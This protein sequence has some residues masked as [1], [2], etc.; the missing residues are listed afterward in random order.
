M[1]I[2]ELASNIILR[3]FLRP[4]E[5]ILSLKSLFEG[6]PEGVKGS[7]FVWRAKMRKYYHLETSLEAVRPLFKFEA[8]RGRSSDLKPPRPPYMVLKW[9]SLA[10]GCQIWPRPRMTSSD[11]K[12]PRNFKTFVW[13]QKWAHGN[14]R[15]KRRSH[16]KYEL[17]SPPGTPSKYSFKYI[18]AV[19]LLFH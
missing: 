18:S 2:L 11:L 15:V 12:R 13:P 7:Y 8:A 17:S 10:S 9:L 3:L 4:F 1:L 5:A 16:V 19:C 6:V 14:R